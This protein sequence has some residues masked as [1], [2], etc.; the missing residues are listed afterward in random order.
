[1]KGRVRCKMILASLLLSGSPGFATELESPPESP[2]LQALMQSLDRREPGA[3]EKF[4]LQV[5]R[6]GTP[7]KERLRSSGIEREGESGVTLYT[8]LV[9][10]PPHSGVWYAKDSSLINA[11]VRFHEFDP[12][13][14][15]QPRMRRIAGSDVCF[16]SFPLPSRAQFSYMLMWPQGRIADPRATWRLV[17]DRQLYELFAD[18]LNPRRLSVPPGEDDYGAQ[19]E[20]AFLTFA[21]GPDVAPNPWLTRRDGVARGRLESFR[22]KSAVLGD[23]RTIWAYLPPGYESDGEHGFALFYDGA[24]YLQVMNVPTMLDNLLA[25]GLLRPAVAIFVDSINNAAREQLTPDRTDFQRFIV[26]ELMPQLKVR[27]ALSTDPRQAVVVGASYGGLCAAHTAFNA[28]ELFGNVLSQ[29]GSYWWPRGNEP[30]ADAIS[31]SG[32]VTLEYARAVRKPVRFYLD[33]GTWEGSD[34]LLSTRRFRDVLSQKGYDVLY[35]EGVGGHD[36]VRWRGDLA[37]GLMALVGT[38]KG[39]SLATEHY[40][41]ASETMQIDALLPMALVAPNS[42]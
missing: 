26:Q 4:W 1:M 3:L 6:M 15:D 31:A 30:H 17:R 36:I 18:P 34:M 33:V 11:E 25:D 41:R 40:R 29:S 2:A 9:R 13:S 19:G 28:P 23:E 14:S 21:E 37:T 16:K 38:P 8:F 10:C 35:S 39:R 12:G 42:L 22:A 7:L 20:N 24:S 32:W 27:Y 5:E